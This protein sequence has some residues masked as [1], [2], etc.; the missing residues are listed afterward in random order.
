MIWRKL[1]FLA[2]TLFLIAGNSMVSAEDIY[3]Q[4]KIFIDSKED[5]QE[6]RLMHLDVVWQ[7]KDFIEVITDKEEISELKTKGFRVEIV[8]EDVVEFYRSRI[9]EKAISQFYSLSQIE[10]EQMF[11]N[12]V[13][14]DL[15]TP[16]ISIGQTLEGRDVYAVKISDNASVDE[17]EPEILFTSAIHCREGITPLVLIEFMWNLLE[18]YGTDPE[19]TYL[20][21]NREMWFV[22]VVNPDGYYYN[23]MNSPGGGGMWRK[24]RRDNGDG[25]YGV[26]LNRNY[27]Y[28]WG[29]D[30]IGSS[31]DPGDETYRGP[32]PFSELETQAMRDFII[33]HNFVITLYFHSYSNLILWPYSYEVGIY[34]PDEYIFSALGRTVNSING[35]RPGPG[36]TLYPTNGDSDDWGYGEQT[37]KDKNYAITIE[38]GGYDD[39]FWPETSRINPLIQENVPVCYYL[40]KLAGNIYSALP[41]DAPV[42]SAPDSVESGQP[43]VLTWTHEDTLNPAVKYQLMEKQQPTVAT[44]YADDFDDWDN[45]G[46]VLDTYD[47]SSPTSF[48]SGE[49]SYAERYI[50]TLEP[51]H[52]Q[53]NDTL[54]FWT[55]YSMSEGWDYAYVQVS[56]DGLYFTNIEG[57]ITTNQPDW[58]DHNLGNGITGWSDWTQG[59]FDLSDY[60]GQDIYIRFYYQDHSLVYAWEGFWIDD[61]YPVKG[62]SV[63]SFDSDTLTD[64]T[65]TLTDRYDW[66]YYYK[67]RAMDADSEWGP[68]SDYK[69]V[70]VGEPQIEICG[71]ADGNG[72]I[73]VGDIAYLVNYMFNGGNPPSSLYQGDADGCGSINMA[74]VVYMMDFYY[75]GGQAPCQ[76]TGECIHET[77]GNNVSL[78]CPVTVQTSETEQVVDIPVYFTNESTVKA[79]TLGFAYNS[80][81][82]EIN[83]IDTVGSVVGDPSMIIRRYF[84]SQNRVMLGFYSVSLTIPPQEDGLLATLKLTIPGGTPVQDIDISAVMIEPGGEFIFAPQGGGIIYPDFVDCG[85][86]EVS[87]V[88]YVCGDANGSGAVNILDATYLINY[89]Y[90]SGPAPVPPEAGDANGNGATNILDATYLIS[91]LYKSGPA[92]IC[93]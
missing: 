85:T 70:V 87:I 77:A 58:W 37:L 29:Y 75:Y 66:E 45:H 78:G 6:L 69:K 33:A 72:V 30:D 74:D 42:I 41:P 15:I 63:T 23:D 34:S 71:D 89:L 55:Y 64:T 81:D 54:K 13:Y 86:A 31:P 19:A 32:G 14:P 25:T 92:P 43:V 53:P 84:P 18:N 52:V 38:V 67:I 2:I 28:M 20:I 26:D 5:I 10:A 39:G 8:H 88:D 59:L 1:A 11:M 91:Y 17:E 60:A 80:D 44:D 12:Y 9:P 7:G 65:I 36:W 61:I 4:A 50:T 93:P 51:Y 82:V 62:F 76:Y 68:W 27:G 16:K 46:F 3:I 79:I 56:T 49:P 35:Y 48:H 83:L 57:N 24:N 47:H 21:D 40:A 90:K 73:N 22:L